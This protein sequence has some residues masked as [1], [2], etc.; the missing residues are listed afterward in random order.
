[1]ML[2]YVEA[3]CKHG[4]V[5]AGLTNKVVSDVGLVAAAAAVAA[6][7]ADAHANAAAAE[8][9]LLLLL[10]HASTGRSVQVTDKQGCS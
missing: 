5:R 10:Q 8:L 9:L 3:A 1:M 4:K 6:A 7:I 2:R